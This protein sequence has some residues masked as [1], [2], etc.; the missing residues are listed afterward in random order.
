MDLCG[1]VVDRHRATVTD[2]LAVVA[3]PAGLPATADAVAVTHRT[4]GAVLA[5]DL[6]DYTDH[7]R[8]AVPAGE[9][10]LLVVA[11]DRDKAARRQ[12][13]ANARERIDLVFWAGATPGELVIQAASAFGREMAIDAE[14]T[15]RQLAQ[16]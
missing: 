3:G 14:R 1:R 15:R 5:T 9:V 8:F 10:G 12:R 6:E 16:E 11:W 7:Y 2:A 13:N 4:S